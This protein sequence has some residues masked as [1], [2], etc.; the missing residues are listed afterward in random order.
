VNMVYAHRIKLFLPFGRKVTEDF[1]E[2][3]KWRNSYLISNR[4][5]KLCFFFFNKCLLVILVNTYV[6]KLF[7]TFGWKVMEEF[8]NINNWPNSYLVGNRTIKLNFLFFNKHREVIMVNAH[9]KKY[10]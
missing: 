9:A 2:I 10:F 6:K 3:I 5:I 8:G 1:A 4:T 7:R